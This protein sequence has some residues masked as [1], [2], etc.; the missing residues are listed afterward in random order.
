M[1]LK[2]RFTRAIEGLNQ[3]NID[4]WIIIGRETNI[5]GE[6]SLLFLMPT[7]ILRLS[8][9]IITSK[10]DK[11]FISDSL[12][13]E[14]I[15]CS[16]LFTEVQLSSNRRD[17]GERITNF[18][19][20]NNYIKSIA[21][22]FSLDKPSSDGLTY[23]QYIFLKNC[24][25]AAEYDGQIVSSMPVM[26]KVRGKKSIEE[27]KK[28]AFTV[29]ES[30]KI[31]E[32]A[33]QYMRVGMSGYDIQCLFNKLVINK[34]YGF[35]WPE[36]DN[37]YVSVGTRSSYL[38]KRPPKDVYIEP[39]DLVNVDFGLKIDGFA[40]DNQRSF[41]ALLPGETYPPTEVQT[42]FNTI[43]EINKTVCKNMKTGLDSAELTKYGNEIMIKNGYENGWKGGYGHEICIFAHN[44]GI[45]AGYNKSQ[46]DM[47]T[48]LEENMTFTLEPA[49]ITSHGRLCQ[50]EVVQVTD[51][52]GKMLSNP[53]N[54]I[55]II[56]E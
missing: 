2:D 32:E 33:R 51:E 45:S 11:I 29:A 16:G 53:Q 27:I 18:I 38:C 23:S 20:R 21:L 6:P 36:S 46:I 24:F 43:Q 50:E 35:S 34:G 47:D 7:E 19:K 28:I 5:L 8:A 4:A 17:L 42:A 48:T 30:M 44:G 31:Y 14:E 39:G 52:G 15:K 56:N 54:E 12:M 49:I 10:G 37:P 55:W 40:S 9:V 13:M 25:D 3:H 1:I 22:N 41:Y 26:K